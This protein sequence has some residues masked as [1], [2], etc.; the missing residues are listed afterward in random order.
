MCIRNRALSVIFKIITLVSFVGG[1][2]LQCITYS[3]F[4]NWDMFAYYTIVSNAVCVIYFLAAIIFGRGRSR[5][6]PRINGAVV[7]CIM[8]TM[9]VYH[10]M[11]SGAGFSMAGTS[12]T[13]N[14]LLHYISPSMA[15]IDW[16]VFS[17]KGRFRVYDPILWTIIPIA[18]LA[19]I[20][21][22]GDYV[23]WYP[24]YFLDI[25][26]MGVKNVIL[27]VAALMCA[28]VLGGY[29]LCGLDKLTGRVSERTVEL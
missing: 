3:Q 4:L 17:E 21:I 5:F 28:Y 1:I 12:A 26:V 25:S 9:L 11:L 13:A 6:L 20:M 8:L 27:Y 14:T 2:V 29:L 24:Y 7:M 23:A 19:V 22:W 10:F 18:Y 15:M 16:I